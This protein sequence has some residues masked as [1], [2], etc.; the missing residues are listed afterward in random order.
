M[1]RARLITLRRWSASELSAKA[2]ANGA[3]ARTAALAMVTKRMT[4]SFPERFRSYAR[5][6]SRK[7]PSHAARPPDA[8]PDRA[9]ARQEADQRRPA[10]ADRDH[11][12][13]L[14]GDQ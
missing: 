1:S 14:Q 4:P 8:V 7:M 11:R 13:R 10:P 5:S 6:G 3:S 12:P 9:A 2:E